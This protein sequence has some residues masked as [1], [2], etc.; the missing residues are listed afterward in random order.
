[1]DGK[2]CNKKNELM[3]PQLYEDLSTLMSKVHNRMILPL[4]SIEMKQ[5]IHYTAEIRHLLGELERMQVWSN[6]D[7]IGRSLSELKRQFMDLEG[8][9]KEQ[10][11]D[12]LHATTIRGKA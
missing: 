2:L 12:G 4:S 11:N 1:M 9:L 8:R 10:R 3:L 7:E 6:N 5:L